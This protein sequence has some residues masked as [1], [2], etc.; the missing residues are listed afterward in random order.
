MAT[1]ITIPVARREP[2]QEQTTTLDGRPFVIRLDWIQRIQ[3]WTI[4]LFSPNGD[5][6]V[7]CKGLVL[8]ADILRQVRYNPAAPQGGLVVVDMQGADVEPDLDSLG[9]RHRILYFGA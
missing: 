6:I 7:Q 1:L 5:A 2:H 4:S 8:G 3:R 9:G